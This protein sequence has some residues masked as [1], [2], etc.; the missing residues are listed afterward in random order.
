[1]PHSKILPGGPVYDRQPDA[2][3]RHE[4]TRVGALALAAIDGQQSHR[5]AILPFVT[6]DEY[7][8]RD[9]AHF[10]L[11]LKAML[12]AGYDVASS[13]TCGLLDEQADCGNRGRPPAGLGLPRRVDC[14]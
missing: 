4:L 13:S 11:E 5:R 10:A 1:M 3:K 2:G 9:S 7:F 8:R 6:H 14:A 12:D